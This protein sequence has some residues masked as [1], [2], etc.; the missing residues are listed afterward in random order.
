VDI[1]RLKKEQ[2]RMATA[3]ASANVAQGPVGPYAAG[4]PEFRV[5]R[6]GIMVVL[7]Q[8]EVNA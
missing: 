5:A 2:Q 4:E 6:K 3:T 1:Y 7:G 8:L